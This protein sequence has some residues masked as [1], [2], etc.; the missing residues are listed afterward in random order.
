MA[1]TKDEVV[2]GGNDK[3]IDAIVIDDNSA[4][5]YIIQGKFIGVNKV[6]AEPL[7]EVLSSWIQL[8]DLIRLQQV[9]NNKLK[10]KLNEVA[11]AL[12]D[13][14]E[15]VF[16]LITTGILSPPAIEDLKTFQEQLA[17]D[18]ELPATLILV[19]NDKLRIKYDL[20]LEKEDP[21]I[22]YDLPL[23]NSK[24]FASMDIAGTR[25]V[26]AAI[27]LKE[28]IHLPGIKEGTL[29]QKNVRQSRF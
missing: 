16:E 20:A 22:N 18:N 5:I 9:A 29:F 1:Q 11:K 13:D 2:D 28:C 26:I 25:A 14:Y 6:D 23:G 8:K 21:I 24:N 19:D 15:V 27:P 12:E 3:Q 4:S 10:R 7:R 17:K